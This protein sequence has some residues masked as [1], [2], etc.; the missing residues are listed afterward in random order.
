V[1]SEPAS[2][3]ELRDREYRG[4]YVMFSVVRAPT[5]AEAWVVTSVWTPIPCEE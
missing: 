1:F 5:T 3:E 4:E 2:E